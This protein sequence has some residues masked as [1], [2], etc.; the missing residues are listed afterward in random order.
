MD[1]VG[2]VVH[3][4]AF[5]LN[6]KYGK[7]CIVAPDVKDYEDLV[8]YKLIRFKSVLIPVM[9][10]YRLGL[11]QMDFNFKR[12]LAATSFNILHAHCP[13]VSGQLAMSLAHKTKQPLVA[14]FHSKYLDDFK[15]VVGNGIFL[16]LLMN[17]II[18]FYNSADYVW[19]PSKATGE[20]LKEYGYTGKFEIMPNGTDFE[21]PGDSQYVR[22]RCTEFILLALGIYS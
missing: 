12:K 21:K 10:P 1:G 19:V 20:T 16:N 11:P 17:K 15:K 22:K 9:K 3:N 18:K 5:W 8:D 7:A 13:F 14:T 2:M 4:Y 6:A